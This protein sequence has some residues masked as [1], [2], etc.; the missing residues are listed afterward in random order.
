M[1]D[2]TAEDGDIVSIGLVKS[3][4]RGLRDTECKLDW[5]LSLEDDGDLVGI[6]SGGRTGPELVVREAARFERFEALRIVGCRASCSSS[7]NAGLSREEYSLP[8]KEP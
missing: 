4:D 7:G 2:R 1:E 5:E 3:P 8:I 6:R